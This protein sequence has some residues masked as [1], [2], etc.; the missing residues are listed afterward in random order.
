[1]PASCAPLP[2]TR[3]DRPSDPPGKPF[4]SG[5]L[6]T[7]PRWRTSNGLLRNHL[8]SALAQ[9]DCPTPLHSPPPRPPFPSTRN[10][11]LGVAEPECAESL[12]PLDPSHSRKWERFVQS[13]NLFHE[14]HSGPP[15]FPPGR[16]RSHLADG[17]AH[18]AMSVASAAL[19]LPD[20]VTRLY[21]PS[22]SAPVRPRL[23]TAPR[24]ISRPLTR[25]RRLHLRQPGRGTPTQAWASNISP[26][27]G[28]V[29]LLPLQIYK[30]LHPSPT[31][32]WL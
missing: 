17:L 7:R 30:S 2:I 5:L 12:H 21:H 29:P 20:D 28:T 1:M 32:S 18:S 19:S 26:V 27:D 13:S 10:L 15:S 31:L 16:S 6:P 3:R 22:S 14:C 25:W 9:A 11:S 23:G 8:P 24:T 4:G